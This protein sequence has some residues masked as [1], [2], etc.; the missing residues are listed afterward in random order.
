M[1]LEFQFI[2]RTTAGVNART[3]CSK[4]QWDKARFACYQ[5][6][7][8]VCEVCSGVGPDHPVECH[9]YWEW[10]DPSGVQKLIKLIALCPT[11]HQAVHLLGSMF[12][13]G[14]FG[15]VRTARN[16][17]ELGGLYLNLLMHAMNVNKWTLDQTRSNIFEAYK[18]Y[19]LRSTL[20]WKVN[21]DLVVDF[22]EQPTRFEMEGFEL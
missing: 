17:I 2:P 1:K 15:T 19:S 21:V 11:C 6:A 10:D 20:Q 16:Y 7:G 13:A 5:R 9:E 4:E 18:Q 12:R 22:T 3:L 8:Y 14:R